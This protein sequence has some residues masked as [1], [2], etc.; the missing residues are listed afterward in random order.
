MSQRPSYFK[1][2]NRHFVETKHLTQLPNI[3][4]LRQF[5]PVNYY[6]F[7]QAKFLRQKVFIRIFSQYKPLC[8]GENYEDRE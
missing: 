3:H 6:G 4:F 8:Y 5:C 7:H 1:R 2:S